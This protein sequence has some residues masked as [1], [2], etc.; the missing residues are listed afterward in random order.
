MTLETFF[1]F[2]HLSIDIT[3]GATDP[4]AVAAPTFEAVTAHP[5]N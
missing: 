4:N 2:I 5:I 1:L 3:Y